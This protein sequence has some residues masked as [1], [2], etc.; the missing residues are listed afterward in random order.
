MTTNR[1]INLGL[2]SACLFTGTA[3]PI[4][5]AKPAVNQSQSDPK[6][7]LDQFYKQY[8]PKANKSWRTMR[9]LVDPATYDQLSRVKFIDVEPFIDTQAGLQSYTIGKPRIQGNQ[10]TVPVQL[11]IGLRPPGT[12]R[13]LTL[14][15]RQNSS[16]WQIRN[17]IYSPKPLASGEPNDLLHVWKP[18]KPKSLADK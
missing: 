17:V 9:E 13:D 12:R 5:L 4:V 10:A 6:V 14:I 7:V 15:L 8:L 11:M 2:I 3:A 1:L 18:D 16:R